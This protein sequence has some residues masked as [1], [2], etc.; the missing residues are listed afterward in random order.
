MDTT[1]AV[2]NSGMLLLVLG[3]AG[4]VLTGAAAL[5]AGHLLKRRE[6]KIR[7]Q[8]WREYR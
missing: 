6:A 2:W 4:M 3:V 7:E 1:L 5:I 8:I